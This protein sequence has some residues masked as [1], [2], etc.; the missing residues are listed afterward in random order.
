MPEKMMEEFECWLIRSLK[1][2]LTGILLVAYLLLVGQWI[3]PGP[4]HSIT[5]LSEAERHRIS[6]WH[7][8]QGIDAGIIENGQ[9]YFYRDGE[10]YK[11]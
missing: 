10:K 8:S 7:R 4:R 5:R 1:F 9:H 6:E 3:S 2:I 11:L